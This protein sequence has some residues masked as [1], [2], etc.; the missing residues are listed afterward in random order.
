MIIRNS[1]AYIAFAKEKVTYVFY[2]SVINGDV[3]ATDD[4]KIYLV[5]TEVKGKITEKENGRVFI[6]MEPE[7]NTVD[8]G[9]R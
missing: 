4:S 7:W 9:I 2:D 6:D 5:N 1:S 3:T 8:N